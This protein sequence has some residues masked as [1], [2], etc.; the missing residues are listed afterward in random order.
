S[1]RPSLRNRREVA[2]RR[3]STED[4]PLMSAADAIAALGGVTPVLEPGHVWLAGAGPGDPALL[5]LA[6][7]AGLAQADMVVHD[8]LVDA[9]VL[10]LANPRARLEFA[11]KR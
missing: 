5:T 6:A 4:P 10:A 7:L 3:R 11:G 8:E 2:L 1:I 9:R